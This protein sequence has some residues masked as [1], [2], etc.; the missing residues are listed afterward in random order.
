[1][2]AIDHK[3]GDKE[4]DEED[5]TDATPGQPL[6]LVIAHD[7]GKPEKNDTIQV[8]FSEPPRRPHLWI[9]RDKTSTTLKGV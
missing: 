2:R 5:F 3:L 9:V 6:S 7:D 8:N 4:F 1:L